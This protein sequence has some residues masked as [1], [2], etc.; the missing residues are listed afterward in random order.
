MAEIAQATEQRGVV[1]GRHVRFAG[2]PG[3]QVGV[4]RLYQSLELADLLLRQLLDRR[5]GEATHDEV[6]L[7][8]A[9][10]PGPEQELAPALIQP[11]ARPCRAAHQLPRRAMQNARVGFSRS[12][13]GRTGGRRRSTDPY[14]AA[15]WRYRVEKQPGVLSI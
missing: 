8:R 4:G 1:V 14:R 11:L 13:R 3:Q 6:H 2:D 15:A 12:S 7:A 5:I 9:A 10:V